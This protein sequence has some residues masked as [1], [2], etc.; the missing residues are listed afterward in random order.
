MK[1]KRLRIED[2]LNATK[3]AIAEGIVPGG[4]VCLAQIAEKINDRANTYTS[5]EFKLGYKIVVEAL[6]APLVQIALNSGIDST[7]VLKECVES[8]EPLGLDALSGNMVNVIEEGI[9]DPAKVT[10]VALENAS[11]I[12][13]MFLTTEVGITPKVK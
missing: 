12:A 8:P 3:A 11:S 13:S 10:R 9:I 6:K 7:K 2:A 4:G 1:E 5:S